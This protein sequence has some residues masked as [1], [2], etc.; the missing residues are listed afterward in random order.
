VVR[1]AATLPIASP[2]PLEH[3]VPERHSHFQFLPVLPLILA[4]VLSIW[5]LGFVVDC[6][7]SCRR[8]VRR[9]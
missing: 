6:N 8:F 9:S 4:F 5:I 3:A 1:G 7:I 2:S